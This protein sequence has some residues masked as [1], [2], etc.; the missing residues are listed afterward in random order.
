[1]N[2]ILFREVISG[3]PAALALILPRSRLINY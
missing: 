2:G 1:L 3:V